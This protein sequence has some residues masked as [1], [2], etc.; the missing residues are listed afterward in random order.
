MDS[1]AAGDAIKCNI[2]CDIFHLKVLDVRN[3]HIPV[4]AIQIHLINMSK[5]DIAMHM[6]D[7]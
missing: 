4:N 1:N 6:F 7:F 2:P 3:R 5:A